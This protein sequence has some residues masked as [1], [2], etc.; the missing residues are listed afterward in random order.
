MYNYYPNFSLGLSR[1]EDT[2]FMENVE[3][4][5]QKEEGEEKQAESHEKD[6]EE[7]KPKS[8]APKALD[9]CKEIEECF[10]DIDVSSF[11]FN[12]SDQ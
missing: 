5:G 10:G 4:D 9:I 11:S 8:A 1:L 3:K 12:S 7:S 2:T 6:D